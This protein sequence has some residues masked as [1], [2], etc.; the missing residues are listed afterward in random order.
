MRPQCPGIN[1]DQ[2]DPRVRLR[3]IH[4][5]REIRVGKREAQLC[6]EKGLNQVQQLLTHVV[7]EWEMVQRALT[8]P[9][10]RTVSHETAEFKGWVHL[11]VLAEDEVVRDRRRR[12]KLLAMMGMLIIL[13]VNAPVKRM[14]KIVRH[15]IRA[16][17]QQIHIVSASAVHA[18]R[19]IDPGG[20]FGR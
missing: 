7:Q 10:E 18:I 19:S 1:V 8:C 9:N 15:E 13:V 4:V 5:K 3:D 2:P 6:V 20:V 16:F 11:D 14:L 17:E 12:T